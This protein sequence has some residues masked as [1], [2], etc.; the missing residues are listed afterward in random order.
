[1][2]MALDLETINE[3]YYSGFA[4]VE[5]IGLNAV[6][7]YNTP[8][9]EWPE[10]LKQ[11]YTYDPEGAERLLDQAGYPR[12]ADGVRFKT[13]FL[14][15]D[16]A[17][18]GFVE[19]AVGYWSDIGVDIADINVV[20][21]PTWIATWG[22]ANYEMS[23]SR[24]A[25]ATDPAWTIG[26]HRAEGGNKFFREW[27]GG[28]EN[29]ELIAAYDAFQAA[30]TIEGQM[31]AHR[32]Y[33]MAYLTEHSQVS[34]PLA[35]LFQVNQPWVGGFNGEF[36]LGGVSHHTI[37]AP[38]LDR[39]GSEAR[40]GILSQRAGPTNQL[41]PWAIEMAAALRA[42]ALSKGA[43]RTLPSAASRRPFTTTI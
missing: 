20:D 25:M 14:H 8:F 31:K 1:M 4:K 12:G 27:V 29:P 37:L 38:P 17:D 7:G 34:G 15:R 28:G 11:Y 43:G 33:D 16:T 13:T 3:T 23:N 19:I 32:E 36:A 22:E 18:L 2:Q 9:A 41:A 6:K 10:E 5:P 35:P 30:T 39:S 24:T 40:N 21:G 26:L 42:A